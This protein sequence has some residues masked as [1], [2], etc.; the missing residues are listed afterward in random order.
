LSDNKEII[1]S[2]ADTTKINNEKIK[3]NSNDIDSLK[4]K[5]LSLQEETSH[6]HAEET[7]KPDEK[8]HDHSTHSWDKTCSDCG[9]DNPDFTDKQYK[10][11]DCDESMGT[12]E[13]ATKAK[14]CSHC[15]SNEG[16]YSEEEG[17]TF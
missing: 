4:Q 12:K 17:Y 11:V 16:A 8:K 13:E 7:M 14:A 9:E 2:I 10:C 1:D 15:S 3:N 5:L 6:H